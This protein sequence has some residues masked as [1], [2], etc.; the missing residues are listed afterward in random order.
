MEKLD[1]TAYFTDSE[2]K[3]FEM[4]VERLSELSL[5][6]IS[7]NKALDRLQIVFKAKKEIFKP[8]NH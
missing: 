5:Q 7:I 2:F 1:K 6:L 8:W 4:K 3:N